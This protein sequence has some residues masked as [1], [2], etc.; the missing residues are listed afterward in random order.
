MLVVM[1]GVMICVSLAATNG[2]CRFCLHGKAHF[3]SKCSTHRPCHHIAAWRVIWEAS[4]VRGVMKVVF[5]HNGH[6]FQYLPLYIGARTRMHRIVRTLRSEI[7]AFR[8]EG[9]PDPWC[10]IWGPVRLQYISDN[11]H[12]G[13]NGS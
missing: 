5:V 10:L 3:C 11:H 12:H 4:E 9:E 1:Y 8:D 7:T 2:P 13:G 6:R